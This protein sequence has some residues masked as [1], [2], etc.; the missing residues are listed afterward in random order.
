MIESINQEIITRNKYLKKKEVKSIYLGGGTPSILNSSEIQSILNT[1]Y[2]KYRI[3]N[4]AEITVE[5]NPEDIN[6]KKLFSYEKAGINRLSIGVQ[7]F[8]DFDLKF[9]NR[10]HNT[11]QAIK[12]IKLAKAMS[13][14]NISVDLIYGLPNQTLNEWSKNLDILFSLDVPHFSAYC[15]T[16]EKKTQLDH[17][18]K[19]KKT[20]LPKDEKIIAQF[21]LLQKKAKSKGF[22]HYE[23]SSFGKKEYFSKHNT[24]YWKNDH[25]LGIG[26]SAHSYNGKIRR[27]NVSSNNTYISNVRSNSIYFEEEI[28][29]IEDQYNEYI[30]TGLRTIWGLDIRVIK[31]RYNEKIKLHFLKEIKKWELKKYVVLN[32]LVYT[33][34]PS[35]KKM[36]DSI[37]S[38]LFIVN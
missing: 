38:D 29:T 16:V 10:S 33:L 14:K 3:S 18:I 37:A 27:W 23:I 11:S 7:S 1:I 8:N 5:C 13:F 12:A 21:N 17:L 24:T 35:G 20:Q 6:R 2:K 26:P 36:A 34:T 9:M 4:S 25:Y 32:S 28:L 31:K 15:L 22:I 30:L 19:T